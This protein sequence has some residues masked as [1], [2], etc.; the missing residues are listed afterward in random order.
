METFHWVPRPGMSI[1]AEPNVKVVKFGDGYEQR[2]PA[3]INNKLD[4]YSVT[5]RIPRREW[6]FVSKFLSD[7]GAVTAFWWTPPSSFVPIKVVC[8][9]WPSSFQ[10]TYVDISCE[11]EEVMA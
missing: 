9:K 10:H 1:K 3:G 5:F 6:A 8:R 7:H 2:Q 4:K 11:F